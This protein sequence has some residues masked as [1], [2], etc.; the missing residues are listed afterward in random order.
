MD[1]WQAQQAFWSGFS[2][3]AYDDQT[4]FTEDD[5]PAYPHI[6][7]ESVDG[8]FGGITTLA[9]HLWNRSESW[10]EI[11]RKAAEIK[12]ALVG[13]GTKLN[14]DTGQI[15]ITIPDGISFAQPAPTGSDDELVQRIM[16]NVS[17]EF[18]SD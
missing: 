14:T 5:L 2:W 7:Y 13:G 11:K 17:A 3:P 12:A 10:A 8:E 16:I 6:T 4:T 1:N 18:L 9:V 15:W